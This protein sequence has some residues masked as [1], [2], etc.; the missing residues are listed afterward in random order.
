MNMVVIINRS[1]FWLGS[2]KPAVTVP[3]GPTANIVVVLS[4]VDRSPTVHHCVAHRGW[5][6]RS[7][8]HQLCA[9]S[10][11]HLGANIRILTRQNSAS[12]MVA[13]VRRTVAR[14]RLHLTLVLQIHLR[15]LEEVTRILELLLLLREHVKH[16]PLR[17]AHSGSCTCRIG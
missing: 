17:V 4:I 9:T 11:N 10:R 5:L 15:V 7:A 6:P 2:A 3:S 8:A 12:I 1:T 16:F 13:V 14:R